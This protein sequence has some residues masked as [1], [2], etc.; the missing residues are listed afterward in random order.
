MYLGKQVHPFRQTG[1]CILGNRCTRSADSFMVESTKVIC[2]RTY[3][4]NF[5][6]AFLSQTDV[7]SS[8]ITP[9]GAADR[10]IRKLANFL[11]SCCKVTNL[12]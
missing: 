9:K 10:I 11:R 1:A 7:E 4:T 6:A 12:F 5:Y 8:S 2:A 3:V